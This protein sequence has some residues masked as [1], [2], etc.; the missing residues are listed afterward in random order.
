[1]RS[2]FVLRRT[3]RFVRAACLA[4]AAVATLAGPAAAQSRTEQLRYPV[5][6]FE[7][8]YALDHPAHPGLAEL[9]S[10]AVE[11]RVTSEGLLP[12]H[13]TTNNVTFPLARVPAGSRFFTGG[14][15]HVSS[16]ILALFE[17][18]GIDGV[19]VTFPQ[20]EA[21]TGR[22]LRTDPGAPLLVRIWTGRIEN[23]ATVADGDRFGD[24]DAA[25]R[26]NHEQHRFVKEG[27]PVQPGG[28]DGLLRVR[29]LEDYAFRLSR[30]PGRRIDAVLRP[31]ELPGATR[32]DY[33]VAEA[34]PWMAY[35][36][37][38]NTGTDAT[39]DWRERFGFSHNQLT[40]RDDVL[41][42]DYVTGSFED[43]HGL[44]GS[45]EAPVFDRRL[46][47]QGFGS[48][49]QYDASEVGVG[50]VDADGDQWQAGGR[51]FLEVFQ[52]RELF[53]DLF[54]GAS[55]REVSVDNDIGLGGGATINEEA[56]ESF[57]LP[58]GGVRV[59]RHTDISSAAIDVS[60]DHNLS[61][62]AGTDEDELI[63]LGSVDPDE[64]FTRLHWDGAASIFLEPALRWRRWA[65]PTTPAS[66]TLAHEVLLTTKGQVSLG[67]R[68]IPQFQHIAG[69]LF[70]VRGYDQAVTAGDTVLI[71]SAEYRLHLPRL[72][73]PSPDAPHV[74]VLG[75][76][77]I[78][79]EN[80]Y[81][82]PD[83]D[84][85]LK[86]FVDAGRVITED[87]KDFEN[88][89]TLISVG[90]GAELLFMRNLAARVDFGW[91]QRKLED[92][93]EDTDSPEIHTAVTVT[94]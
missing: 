8:E 20:I 22:D 23:V 91:P 46:R 90:I 63:Q 12:P 4:A 50:G 71:G 27:S 49:S 61:S 82:R 17:A 59:R 25:A 11:L 84:F 26:T 43:V 92:D 35:A 48:W 77:K 47:V 41:R 40:G 52:Y 9:Q 19:L 54:A 51:V 93:S 7:I 81:G 56:D 1:M 94:F 6:A 89:Q 37:L 72:L 42:F 2:G 33:H 38:S 55:W 53:V 80:V 45:Y 79:P 32:V 14:L 62:L 75:K 13:P 69:G 86:A 73:Y 21:E 67:D 16:E 5:S 88:N 85:V 15:R 76:V 36:Q 30:H 64:S 34:K 10:L 24:E 65:D 70:T 87:R 74:P 28:D 18:R 60:I 83:W 44:W 58:E 3:C 57:F 66:S 68:L 78:R 39:T 31:G 29:E